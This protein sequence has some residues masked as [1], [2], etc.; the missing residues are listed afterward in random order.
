MPDKV[1][2]VRAILTQYEEG[3]ITEYEM[4]AKLLLLSSE[5]VEA[6]KEG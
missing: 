2:E 1:E 4:W 3:C 5:G 6:T